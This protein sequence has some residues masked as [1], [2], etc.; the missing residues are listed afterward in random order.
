MKITLPKIDK[1]IKNIAK[2]L[3]IDVDSASLLINQNL[4]EDIIEV[5]TNDEWHELL[6]YNTIKN[7][8]ET[9]EIIAQYLKNDNAVIYIFGD[10]DND[11]IQSTFIAYDCFKVLT[12]MLNSQCK[13]E[14]YIPE[15]E[16]GYGLSAEWCFDL[17]NN[18]NN[19][20][21]DILV[22]TVDN[23]ITKKYEVDYLKM[24]NIEVVVTDHH[25]PQEGLIPDCLVVDEFLDN[26]NEY[27][28]L[29]GA[30]VIF[31]LCSYLLVN[32]FKDENEYNMFYLP[33]VMTAT[34]S[35]MVPATLENSLF[36][37]NGLNMLHNYDCEYS[38]SF[39]HY[40]DFKSSSFKKYKL[41]PKD[42]AFEYGP[43]INACGRMGNAKLAFDYLLEKN[44]L[45]DTYNEMVLLNDQR[46]T[47]TKQLTEE[48]IKVIDDTNDLF[49][50]VITNEAG[51]CAGLLANKLVEHYNK[52]A[53]VFS[54]TKKTYVGSARSI[55][56]IE[57][58][59]IFKILKD[60]NTIISYGGHEAACGIEVNK[61]SFGQFKNDFNNILLTINHTLNN[62]PVEDIEIQVDKQITVNELTNSK[63]LYNNIMFYNN[64]NKPLF[65]FENVKIKSV[66]KSKNNPNN[67]QFY[68]E[69]KTGISNA[70]CWG[71]GETYKKIGE[72]N[73]VNLIFELEDFNGK[74]VIDIKYIEAA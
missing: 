62:N 10:Y 52:P 65:Y 1:Y 41:T 29:C 56:G 39:R 46:K 22:V 33:N 37:R 31:K 53:I 32:I 3:N 68:F 55:Q 44:D 26:E 7:I 23:G 14:Y 9:S 64:I 13:I 17:V 36:V 11:G 34:I 51:G 49:V 48:A 15:R 73:K 4:S 43:Q 35:D 72:P 63:Y 61:D 24:N 54:E 58:Q 38:D 21:K 2:K 8:P 40:I 30:G 6:P 20:S 74:N 60:N 70:W 67:I 47:L 12:E 18:K 25:C 16:E 59:K 42:I 69:D 45:T 50:Y 19:E 5:L 71:F 66:W 57:L 27:M 28:G